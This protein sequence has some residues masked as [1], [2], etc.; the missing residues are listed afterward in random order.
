MGIKVTFKGTGGTVIDQSEPYRK[1]LDLMSGPL[2]LTLSKGA[3]EEP[4]EKEKEKEKETTDDEE[5]DD[6]PASPEPSPSPDPPASPE[7][8]TDD[9]NDSNG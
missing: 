6:P 5:E 3:T 4:K 1:R 2:V 7:P 9:N 8:S